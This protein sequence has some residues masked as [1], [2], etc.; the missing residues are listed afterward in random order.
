M[1]AACA[2]RLTN[3]GAAPICRLVINENNRRS[4]KLF[5]FPVCVLNVYKRNC[6]FC[7]FVAFQTSRGG[8]QPRSLGI[9]TG[10]PKFSFGLQR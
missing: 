2:N 9:S 10:L 5:S 4:A 8:L 3:Q 7:N 1:L 6:T